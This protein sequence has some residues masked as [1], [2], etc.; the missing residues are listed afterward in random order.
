MAS[1]AEEYRRRFRQDAVLRVTIDARV[2]LF[3]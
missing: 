1:I 2:H 3:E